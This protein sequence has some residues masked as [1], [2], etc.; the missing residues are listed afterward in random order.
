MEHHDQRT[1]FVFVLLND[2]GDLGVERFFVSAAGSADNVWSFVHSFPPR[3]ISFKVNI[4]GISRLRDA[5]DTI[6]VGQQGQALFLLVE[7]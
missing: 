3:I 1:F 4:S 7:P 6:A 5:R 2:L